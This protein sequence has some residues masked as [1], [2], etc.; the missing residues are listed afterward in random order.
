MGSAIALAFLEG[1]VWLTGLDLP[2][3]WFA[4]KIDRRLISLLD[5][6]RMGEVYWWI[7]NDRRDELS[8]ALLVLADPSAMPT[9]VHCTHG[10]DRTGTLVALALYVCGVPPTLIAEDYAKSDARGRSPEG[11]WHM[12]SM[13][14]PHL[15]DRIQLERWCGAHQV[16]NL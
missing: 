1:S 9:L 4:D 8:R 2:E 7:A 14:P 5:N 16:T 15:V 3:D 13:I 12:R 11:Q 10:K 6:T